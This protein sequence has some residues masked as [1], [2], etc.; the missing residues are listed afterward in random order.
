MDP[1]ILLVNKYR[2]TQQVFTEATRTYGAVLI[3]VTE[4][5][6]AAAAIQSQKFH[7][8]FVDSAVPGAESLNLRALAQASALNQHTPVLWMIECDLPGAG[9]AWQ[10]KRPSQTA[11]LKTS[12]QDICQRDTVDRR[13]FPRLPFRTIVNFTFNGQRER[14]ATVNLS[15]T[16]LLVEISWPIARGQV[17]E[18]CLLLPSHRER[19]EARVKAVRR[20]GANRVGLCFQNLTE[21]QNRYVNAFLAEHL[22]LEPEAESPTPLEPNRSAPQHAEAL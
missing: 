12:L 14:G 15:A 18:V 10:M 6:A 21:T 22:N 8:I 4:A 16:G 13:R 17:L 1:Q 9:G 2:R 7:G 5:E 19:V 3:C 11:E 20:E